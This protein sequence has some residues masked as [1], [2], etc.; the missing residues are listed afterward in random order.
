MVTLLDI[1]SIYDTSSFV[2]ANA[3]ETVARI[4]VAS[5]A[6]LQ[7]I[8]RGFALLT[9]ALCIMETFRSQAVHKL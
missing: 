2:Y 5:Y 6:P 7:G 3:L 4:T 9:T 1:I 8:S